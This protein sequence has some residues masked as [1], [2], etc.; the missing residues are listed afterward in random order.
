VTNG[1]SWRTG[2][3]LPV[4]RV[5]LEGLDGASSSDFA[6]TAAS[7]LALVLSVFSLYLQRG[8]RRPRLKMS[9]PSV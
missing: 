7:V 2:A 1:A 3:W 5:G 4:C 9:L 6:H 8:D